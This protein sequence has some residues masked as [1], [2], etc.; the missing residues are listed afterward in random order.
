MD[1]TEALRLQAA[2]KYVL[3]ELPQPLMEEYEEHFFD[4]AECTL[5]ITAATAFASA[6]PEVFRELDRQKD[7]QTENG[8]AFERWFGW[9]RPVVAVPACAVLLLFL[10]YQNAVT[11]PAAKSGA[12]VAMAQVYDSSFTLRGGVRGPGD[13]QVV[14]VHA[15]ESFGLNFDFTPSKSFDHYTGQLLDESGHSLLQVSLPFG[16]TNKEV[17]FVV[18]AGRVHAG[19]YNLVIAGD[20][21]AGQ[22]VKGPEVYRLTFTV[23]I[24]P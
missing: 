10:G 14:P 15:T 8:S 11:I 16:M 19:K 5:D 22:A 12:P 17:H 13:P 23:E 20:P 6:C 2:E 7:S 1:H 21:A 9:F 24:L 3:R 4:C 18:P